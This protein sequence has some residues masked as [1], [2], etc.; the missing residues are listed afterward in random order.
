LDAIGS[1]GQ[2]AGIGELMVVHHAGHVQERSRGASRLRDWPDAEWRLVREAG[3]GNEEP[4]PDAARFLIAEGRDVAVPE[5][6][7][8]FNALSKRLSVAG[9]NRTQHKATKDEPLVLDAIKNSPGISARDLRAALHEAGVGSARAD[10]A[11]QAAVRGGEVHTWQRAK[12]TA[13]YHAL[14]DD[15][16]TPSECPG[17]KEAGLS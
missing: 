17:A 1:L 2:E 16:G 10:K 3:E 8:A 11:I 15:C 7:L 14:S 4:P 13:K 6:K 9:G 5:T 12:N